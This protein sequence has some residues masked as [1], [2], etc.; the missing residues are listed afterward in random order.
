VVSRVEA[1]PERYLSEYNRRFGNVLNADNAAT[2]FPEYTENPARYRVA[3]HPAAQWIRDELF[4]R[5]LKEPPVKGKNSVVFTAGGSH[6]H[7]SRSKRSSYLP[8]RYCVDRRRKSTTEPVPQMRHSPLNAAR[9]ETLG[10]ISNPAGVT[11]AGLG[12]RRS[13]LRCDELRNTATLRVK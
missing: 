12:C 4:R 3:V 1:D 8:N 10:N 2:L 5:A 11:G 9:S 13:R 6:A 7:T